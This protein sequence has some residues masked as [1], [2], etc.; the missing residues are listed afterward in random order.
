MNRTHD[1]VALA[2]GAEHR[3]LH[4][5]LHEIERLLAKGQPSADGL[6]RIVDGLAV[7]RG[8]LARHFEREEMGGFLDEAVGLAPR[9]SDEAARL[10]R[11]HPPFL[12]ELDGILRLAKSRKATAENYTALRARATDLFRGLRMHEAGE[13]H[14]L[15]Q[16]FPSD[17]EEI[18]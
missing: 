15:Q 2:I 17:A 1:H 10:M 6:Q 18:D 3:E 7:L 16:V 8:Q 5:R 14:L 11:E 9:F 4:Q 13:T 12:A